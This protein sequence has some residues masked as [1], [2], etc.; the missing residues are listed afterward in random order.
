MRCNDECATIIRAF[1]VD[2]QEVI[3]SDKLSWVYIYF[4][5][6]F[7]Q[8]KLYRFNDEILSHKIHILSIF[9]NNEMSVKS[10]D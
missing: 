2:C 3:S 6:H 1:V 5:E 10:I 4:D 8:Q 7:G 9:V